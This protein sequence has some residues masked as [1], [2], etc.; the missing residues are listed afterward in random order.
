V[1]HILRLTPAEAE[2]L[3]DTVERRGVAVHQWGGVT[4]KFGYCSVE[5]SGV[6]GY[7]QHGRKFGVLTHP[8]RIVGVHGD[9]LVGLTVEVK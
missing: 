1:S 5:T 7:N 3:A 4:Y 2:Y 9:D 6:L 8:S